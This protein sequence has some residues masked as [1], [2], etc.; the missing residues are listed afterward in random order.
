MANEGPDSNGSQFF[1]TLSKLNKLDGKNVV[2]GRV[3]DETSFNLIEMLNQEYGS[4]DGHP[5]AEIVITNS[6]EFDKFNQVKHKW[7]AYLSKV[8]FFFKRREIDLDQYI[9]F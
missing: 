9:T 8:I 1:I 2:V 7:K 6:G 4:E 3:F 5:K